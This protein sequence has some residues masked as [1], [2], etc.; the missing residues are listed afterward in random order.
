MNTFVKSFVFPFLI[1]LLIFSTIALALAGPTLKMIFEKDDII[2]NN[3]S[4]I[5]GENDDSSLSSLTS[6]ASG[7]LSLLLIGTDE[8]EILPTQPLPP[9]SSDPSQEKT[10]EELIKE[11]FD[12]LI[13]GQKVT[14]SRSVKFLTLVSFDSL[15]RKTTVTAIPAESYVQVNNTKVTMDTACYYIENSLFGLDYKYFADYATSLTGCYVDYYAY[16][17]IDDY[18][19]VTDSL[20]DITLTLDESA[21][22]TDDLGT[23]L[24]SY[25]Q[26][27]QALKGS[28]IKNIL[29]HQGFKSVFTKTKLLNQIS[30]HVLNSCATTAYYMNFKQTFDS[31][32]LKFYNTNIAYESFEKHIPLLFSH[33]FYTHTLLNIIGDVSSSDGKLHFTP[34]AP[35]TIK[36]FKQNKI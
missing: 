34:N 33:A 23:V 2:Q 28:D 8:N 31:L 26:G 6:H 3:Q 12:Q 5:D 7:T 4:D 9:A 19:T 16:I 29:N 1:S 17:D 24:Y 22:K 14:P 15:T 11:K 21:S 30:E 32:V 18:I 35:S 36:L 25:S 20:G 13:S 27:T 10:E